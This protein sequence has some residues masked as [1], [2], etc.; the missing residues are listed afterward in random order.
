MVVRSDIRKSTAVESERSF[1]AAIF[2]VFAITVVRLLWIASGA[3]DLY[4][5]EQIQ[6][7]RFDGKTRVR[8]GELISR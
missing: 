6:L 8:F 3:T 4:P 1:R 7:M 2:I 5:V